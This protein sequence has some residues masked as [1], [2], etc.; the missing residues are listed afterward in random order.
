MARNN[1]LDLIR[2]SRRSVAGVG[3]VGVS[4]ASAVVGLSATPAHAATVD[5]IGDSDRIATAIAIYE[6]DTSLY[7][8]GSAVLARADGYADALVAGS[9]AAGAKAP[10]FLTPSGGLDTRVAATLKKHGIT[11]VAVIGGAKALSP[12]V[13]QQLNAQGVTTRRVAGTDRFDTARLVATYVNLGTKRDSSPVFLATGTNYVDALS[14]VPAA[15]KSGAVILLSTN[16]TLDPATAAY[17]KSSATTGVVAVG[18]PAAAAAKAH[19]I[20]AT[21][22][23]G[24]DRFDTATLIARTYFGDAKKAYLASGTVY[25]DAM[26]GGPLAA[27]TGAPILMTLPT[28]LPAATRTWLDSKNVPVTVLGGPRA[29]STDVEALVR[30]LVASPESTPTPSP[31]TPAPTPTTPPPAGG[32]GGGGVPISDPVG[33]YRTL[34]AAALAST[35]TATLTGTMT[36]GLITTNVTATGSPSSNVITAQVAG[37]TFK[38]DAAGN[39]TVNASENMWLATPWSDRAAE[40]AGE[41]VPVTDAQVTELTGLTASELTMRGLLSRALT[42]NGPFGTELTGG[43]VGATAITGTQGNSVSYAGGLPTGASDGKNQSVTIA[44]Q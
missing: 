27:L 13:E 11:K 2:R 36:Y 5:R 20:N 1:S 18:G 26:A 4:V 31:P 43:S 29:V 19:G 44:W 6:S 34:R 16:R 22:L 17:L 10:L 40:L 42:Q 14:A 12:R 38:R 7:A 32:G 35:R 9:A 37:A 3:V 25:A 24:A 41:D 8:G 39:M 15:H 21:P 28:T 23:I 30:T 33:T